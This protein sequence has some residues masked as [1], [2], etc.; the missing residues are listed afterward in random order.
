MY[1]NAVTVLREGGSKP[2]S[3]FYETV[4]SQSSHSVAAIIWL[5]FEFDHNLEMRGD[6]RPALRLVPLTALPFL[7]STF[8]PILSPFTLVFCDQLLFFPAFPTS[9]ISSCWPCIY[10]STAMLHSGLHGRFLKLLPLRYLY[11]TSFLFFP[12]SFSFNHSFGKASNNAIRLY[13]FICLAFQPYSI[14]SCISQRNV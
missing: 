6:S 9:S 3:F 13:F 4:S 12:L 2:H 10:S 5:P 8:H 11:C 7:H 1:I 14:K